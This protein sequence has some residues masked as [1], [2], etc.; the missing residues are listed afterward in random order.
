[1]RICFKSVVR[2]AV[3]QWISIPK[4]RVI[5]ISVYNTFV[6]ISLGLSPFFANELHKA[7]GTRSAMFVVGFCRV[8]AA[9]LLF[10]IYKRNKKYHLA[11]NKSINV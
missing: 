9:I 4:N 3:F 6:N 2:K 11:I 7:L 8:L 10:I 5:Y 1:M